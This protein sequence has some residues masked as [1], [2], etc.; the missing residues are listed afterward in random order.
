MKTAGLGS[1]TSKLLISFSS[2]YA[3]TGISFFL[4]VLPYFKFRLP[5]F[6]NMAAQQKKLMPSTT[7]VLHTCTER[8]STTWLLLH[9]RNTAQRYIIRHWLVVSDI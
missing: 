5:I 2:V 7:A 9:K 6:V 1:G 3:I 4:H 8:N